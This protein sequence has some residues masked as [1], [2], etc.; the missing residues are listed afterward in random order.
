LSDQKFGKVFPKISKNFT[1]TLKPDFQKFPAFF[2]RVE[3]TKFVGEKRCSSFPHFVEQKINNVLS[4]IRFC[5][6]QQDIHNNL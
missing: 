1:F 6:P 3:K 2:F 4:Q 5:C